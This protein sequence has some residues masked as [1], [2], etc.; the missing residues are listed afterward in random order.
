METPESQY[1]TRD[2]L[3]VLPSAQPPVG[4]T[5]QGLRLLSQARKQRAI[6]ITIEHFS[7]LKLGHFAGHR[8]FED[9]TFMTVSKED[10]LA[11]Y[12]ARK[13]AKEA[14]TSRYRQYIEALQEAKLLEEQQT[15]VAADL[16][17][18]KLPAELAAEMLDHFVAAA[19]PALHE[20]TKEMGQKH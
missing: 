13:A 9:I 4:F 10:L 7:C 8:D 15:I 19:L 5:G 2:L 6:L 18:F 14:A 12:H 1:G 20:P 16:L 3:E 17:Y 11:Q